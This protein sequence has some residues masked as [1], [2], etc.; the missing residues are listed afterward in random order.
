MNSLINIQNN[1][2]HRFTHRTLTNSYSLELLNVAR[3]PL[4]TSVISG[5]VK[6]EKN[7]QAEAPAVLPASKPF[8]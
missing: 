8:Y 6:E 2:A 7:I 3:G 4:Q 1:I 5:A